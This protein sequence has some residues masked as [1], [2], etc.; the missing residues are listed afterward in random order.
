MRLPMRAADQ[1]SGKQYSSD[2]VPLEKARKSS[3]R[4]IVTG[5]HGDLLD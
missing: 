5:T 1:V 3:T 2:R 4:G